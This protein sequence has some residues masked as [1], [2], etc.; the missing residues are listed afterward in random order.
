M[1]WHRKLA[2][3]LRSIVSGQRVEQELGDELRFHLDGLT[4]ELIASG[5]APDEARREARRQLG[6]IDQIKEECR[7]ARRV[8]YLE[9]TL[10][11]VRYGL[12]SLRRSP[13]FSVLAI[14]TL[15]LGIG[16]NTAIFTAVDAVLLR[17]LPYASPDQLVFVWEDATHEGFPRNNVSPADYLDWKEQNTVFADMA[18]TRSA[19]ANLIG[20]GD[21]ETVSGRLA[22]HNLFSILGVSPA[23]GRAFTS[24]EERARANV[25]LLTDG[26]WRRRYGADPSIV[27]RTIQMDDQP[28]VVVGVMPRSF[29][30]PDRDTAF[31]RPLGIEAYRSN[32]GNHYLTVYARLKPDATIERANG[33]MHRVARDLQ[34]RFPA[35]NA[36]RSAVVMPFRDM[37]AGDSRTALLVLFAAAGSVLLIACAN[38]ANLLLARAGTRRREIAVRKALGAGQLRLLRQFAT[39]SAL[40][41]LAGG[42][43]G[44]VLGQFGTQ[45]L[46]GLVPQ[47]LPLSALDVDVR[48]MAFGAAVTLATV[49]LFGVLPAFSSSRV[50]VNDSLKRESRGAVAGLTARTRH[51]LVVCEVTLATMLL[52]GA[53]LMIQTLYNMK[54]EDIGLRSDHLLT[55]RMALPV[56]RYP[57][58][59]DRASYYER[60]LEQTRTLPGVRTA[61]FVGNLPFTT[62]GNA[63][64]YIIE[65]RPAPPAGSGQDTL[66]R[67]VTRDY[68]ATIGATVKE[69]RAFNADDRAGTPRVAVINEHFA[70][71]H[72]NGA[73]PIGDR[74]RLGGP[75]G[76]TFTIVG[77]VK[78]LR[79]RGLEMAMKPATYMMIEQ[80]E[81]NPGA[82]LVVRTETEP[83]AQSKAVIGAIRSVDPNQP[84]TLVRS[85]DDIVDVALQGR[86][87][88]MTLLSVFAGLAL[89]LASLGIY[90]VLSYV[91]SQRTREIGMRMA[92]GASAAGVARAFVRQGLIL[93]TAGLTI[94]V[95]A[96]IVMARAMRT[97]LYEVAPTDLRIYVAGVGILCT[98]A[99]MACYLPARRAARIDPIVALRED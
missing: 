48:V 76:R 86:N 58:P 24:E 64:S 52:V 75:N 44:V 36:N 98:V 18:A 78:D 42:A 33:D 50:N 2:L 17:P 82:F 55:V 59:A 46:Q 12:R 37:V 34:A 19:S 62:M 54:T 53:G 28:Y 66:Y 41:A 6:A 22:S 13:G 1:R 99:M 96:S 35:T 7:D 72:W 67:P 77:V 25:V 97:M 20:D 56:V 87:L 92:L 91:V 93:T 83:L 61:A 32:R 79:E 73:S 57:D 8:S 3:R 47:A 74:I 14:A 70:R 45:L 31:F 90:G 80:G 88:Q 43:A 65:G 81:A 38:L 23:I 84:V 68:F 71:Q 11:D 30:F 9:Q 89:L 51:A 94:G 4:E 16:A 5:I 69:G 27:G 85:M 15:A 21:P 10:Q 26:L 95:I 49:F 40:L 39:E 29:C 60:I 63:I